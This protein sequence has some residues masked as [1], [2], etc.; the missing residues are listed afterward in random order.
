M[1]FHK[2]L[3]G[4]LLALLT[5]VLLLPSQAHAAGTIDLRRPCGLNLAY[6][7][8]QT[9]LVGQIF[10]I[11][12]TATVD[13]V[14][15]LTVT[16]E[17]A[18]FNVNIR[19]K[20]DEAWKK[21]A[22]TLEGY[23]LRDRIVPA[24]RGST[25]RWGELNFPSEG[26]TLTPGLYL[27]LGSRHIQ[28]GVVYDSQP[29]MAVLPT[30]DQEADDWQYLVE[31]SP[32]FNSHGEPEDGDTVD[33]RVLKIWRD[34]GHELERPHSVTAQLLKDGVV[35][36]SVTLSAANGWGHT[37]EDLDSSSQWLVTEQ[38]DA[39]SDYTVEIAREG[40][41]LVMVNTATTDIPDDPVPESP[42]DPDEPDN[43]DEPDEPDKPK[44][45]E[46]PE[47]PEEP[48][49]DLDIPDEDVPLAF[50]PQTGQLWWPVPLLLC[51]GLLMIVIG[52]LRRREV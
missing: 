31:A 33:R 38:T 49:G 7:D 15:E 43:P 5:A 44:S 35:V 37:W 14:G 42:N 41:T 39:G 45:P 34:E 32:K 23:V 28:D 20:N 24:D 40:A 19:G 21:L 30:L 2:R 27:V 50:L 18:Q 25:N 36:D 3:T 10:S 48:D 17:F 1:T 47:E 6:R 26:K 46:E 4:V 16:D 13:E 8:G 51:G 11:Y 52:L 12:L 9:P 29:F 22:S